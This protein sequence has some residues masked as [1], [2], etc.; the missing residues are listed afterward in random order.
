MEV[1]QNDDAI[2]L[3]QEHYALKILERRRVDNCNILHTTMDSGLKLSKAEK[4]KDIDATQ[5]RRS[6]S[7]LRYLLHTRPNQSFCVGVLSSYMQRPQKSHGAEIK[8]CLRYRKR[9]TTLGLVFKRAGSEIPKIIGYSDSSYNIDPDHGKSTA[10]Y[11]LK[12]GENLITWC[13]NKQE[14]VILSSC[15]AEFLA[16][17]KA[18]REIIWFQ[19]LLSGVMEQPCEKVI[20]CIDNQSTISFD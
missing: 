16:G 2:T 7:C 6:V 4:E 5:Y 20:I 9:S 17:T 18:A 11:I 12:F 1:C 8:Q 19:K 13:S 3:Q 15:E 10:S 14:T